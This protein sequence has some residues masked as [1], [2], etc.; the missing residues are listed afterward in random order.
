[1]TA[2]Y[3]TKKLLSVALILALFLHTSCATILNGRYQ[4]VAIDNPSGSKILVD[5]EEPEMKNGL[6][7]L[8]RDRT[9]KQITITKDGYKDEHLVAAPYRVSP[10]VYVSILFFYYPYIVDVLNPKSLTNLFGTLIS[11]A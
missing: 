1:M 6:V 9:V 7:K 8:R 10:L 3:K 5:G 2:Y 4:K 11:L